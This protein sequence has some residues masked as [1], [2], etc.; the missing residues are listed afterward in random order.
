MFLKK[1]NSKEIYSSRGFLAFSFLQK[2]ASVISKND[3]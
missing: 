1:S 3:K 2:L